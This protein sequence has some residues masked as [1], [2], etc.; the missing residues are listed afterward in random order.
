MIEMTGRE[1]LG[2][3]LKRQPVDRIGLYE[4][5]WGDTRKVWTDEG[6]I[7]PDEDLADHFGFDLDIAWTFTSTR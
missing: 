1:R 3:I 7:A 5:F 4:H 6:H 2:N